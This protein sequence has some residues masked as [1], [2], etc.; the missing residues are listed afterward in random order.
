MSRGLCMM[1]TRGLRMLRGFRILPHLMVD[2]GFLVLTRGVPILCRRLRVLLRSLDGRS[3]HARWGHATTRFPP[4]EA[5][6]LW[7]RFP[8]TG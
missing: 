3:S 4:R 8:R 6:P 1:R 5:Q 2:G 7:M